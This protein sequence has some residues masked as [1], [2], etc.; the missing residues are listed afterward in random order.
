MRITESQLRQI[1]REELGGPA[2]RAAAALHTL[3]MNGDL[4][5]YDLDG[6]AAWLARNPQMM[7]FPG[8]DEWSNAGVV[9]DA[10]LKIM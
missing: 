8:E 4:D 3:V 5:P 9:Q 1:I 2:A 10:L 6:I 7:P